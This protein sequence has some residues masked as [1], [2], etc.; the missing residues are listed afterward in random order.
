V[1]T[2]GTRA[3]PLPQV[4]DDDEMRRLV[5]QVMAPGAPEPFGAYVFRT[6]QPGAA[7]AR[8]LETAVLWETFG[9]S[10]EALSQEYGDYEHSSFFFCILDHR[11]QLPAGMMRVIVPSPRGFKSLNDIEPVWGESAAS[12]IE[13]AGL[14]IDRAKT[15]DIATLAVAPEYRG[16]AA[17]G[18]VT[19]GLYQSLIMAAF[20]CGVEWFVAIFDMPVLR[21]IRWKL[22]LTW[23][24]FDGLAPARYLGSVA[25]IPAWC[26]LLEAE[27]KLAKEDPDLYAIL[28]FG[29]GLEPALRT[30]DLS[31][32]GDLEVRRSE[33]AAG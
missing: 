6:G 22:R 13:R 25:S 11:R 9:D 3:M 20:R 12:V 2:I 29:E 33:R 27:R 1:T 8:S 23:A 21:L 32:I 7:L 28:R 4:L 17:R 26:D 15:W 30:V 5:A 14:E 31:D 19:M 16:K 24:G 18:L 10:P